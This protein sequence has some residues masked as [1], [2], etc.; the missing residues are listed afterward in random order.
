M[1][2]DFNHKNLIKYKI[3]HS[4]HTQQ[5]KQQH[6]VGQQGGETISWIVKAKRVSKQNLSLNSPSAPRGTVVYLSLASDLNLQDVNKGPVQYHV[7]FCIY[8]NSL[9]KSRRGLVCSHWAPL[10]ELSEHKNK[11]KPT[12]RMHFLWRFTH[13]CVGTHQEARV[14][15]SERHMMQTRELF[16]SSVSATAKSIFNRLFPECGCP[17][18]RKCSVWI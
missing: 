10:T 11:P 1:R 12:V 2:C 17:A 18:K 3:V 16:Q 15:L 4:I 9:F 8:Y 14:F 7:H 6:G 5:L 13:T